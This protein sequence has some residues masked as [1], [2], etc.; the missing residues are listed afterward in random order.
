VQQARFI[1]TA[2]EVETARLAVGRCPTD[3]LATLRRQLAEQQA[4]VAADDRE[5]F[6]ELDDGFHRLVC[7]LAGI[8]FAWA[9]DSPAQRPYG[10]GALPEPRLRRGTALAD[11]R[12]IYAALESRD[13]G[14]R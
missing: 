11:H 4:A 12:V 7:A 2:L 14:Q 8:G 9:P 5:R 13:I 3:D 6:H 1:R 10:P